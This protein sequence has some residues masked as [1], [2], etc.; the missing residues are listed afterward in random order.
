MLTMC[1]W[2]SLWLWHILNQDLIN[3]LGKYKKSFNFDY[4][5][6]EN[7]DDWN[8]RRSCLK[9][10][11]TLPVIDWDW[12][13]A[14]GA[15]L[16]TLVLVSSEQWAK[17]PVSHVRKY[18]VELGVSQCWAW[19]RCVASVGGKRSLLGNSL[20]GVL[21]ELRTARR[22]TSHTHW[23]TGHPEETSSCFPTFIVCTL[24]MGTQSY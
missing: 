18:C 5:I 7:P 13:C 22:H 16:V 12:K 11:W 4:A 24:G 8:L 20:A 2:I 14:N 9:E 23:P 21:V 1:E 19:W 17:S 10:F 15:I 6:R 3:K